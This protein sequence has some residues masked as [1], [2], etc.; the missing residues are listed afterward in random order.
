MVL[1]IWVLVSEHCN[2][3]FM[4]NQDIVCFLFLSLFY[5]VFHFCRSNLKKS[6][7]KFISV[8]YI[9]IL[10]FRESFCGGKKLEI[11]KRLRFTLK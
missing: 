8:I 4:I 11:M 3:K 1:S 5:F 9:D 6:Y 10:G 2:L 7:M